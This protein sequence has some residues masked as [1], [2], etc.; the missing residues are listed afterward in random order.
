MIDCDK[1]IKITAIAIFIVDIL[2]I[3]LN[4]R[5]TLTSIYGE[6]Y[7]VVHGMAMVNAL[8][9]F[10]YGVKFYKREA[11]IIEKIAAAFLDIIS[12]FATLVLARCVWLLLLEFI[13]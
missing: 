1:F 3:I 5:G 13:C 2:G 7:E 11:N 9:L 10:Y 4:T 8:Y 12:F 6:H